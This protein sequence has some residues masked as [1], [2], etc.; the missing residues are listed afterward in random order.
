MVYCAAFPQ[1]SIQELIEIRRSP[2]QWPLVSNSNHHHGRVR[3]HVHDRDCEQN[4]FYGVHAL[5]AHNSQH[6]WI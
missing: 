3:G 1:K 6:D 5:L 2:R 4:F